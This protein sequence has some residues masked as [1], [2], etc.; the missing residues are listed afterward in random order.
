MA[1]TFSLIK[2]K[3]Y[4]D[5]YESLENLE[6]FLENVTEKQEKQEEKERASNE[7][8]KKIKEALEKAKKQKKKNFIKPN[9]IKELKKE[10]NTLY[11][12]LNK[13]NRKLFKYKNPYLENFI[14]DGDTFKNNENNR[15]YVIN[16]DNSLTLFIDDNE[17]LIRA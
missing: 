11:Y 13:K 7:E 9:K 2:E 8:A 3:K 1:Y 12:Y 16:S 5:L 6:N 14:L 4:D 10:E 15:K 17:F